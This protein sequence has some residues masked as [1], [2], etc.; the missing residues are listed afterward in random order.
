MKERCL[1]SA[2]DLCFI[3]ILKRCGAFK[4]SYWRNSSHDTKVMIRYKCVRNTT[5]I[6]LQLTNFIQVN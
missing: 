1:A 5:G 6:K 3:S 2:H 4:L